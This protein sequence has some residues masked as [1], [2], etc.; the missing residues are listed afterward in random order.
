MVGDDRFASFK[1]I[2][3]SAVFLPSIGNIVF[4]SVLFVLIF[5]V[6]NG[7]LGDGDTGYH[8]KTG[9]LILQ[10][11]RI[12]YDDP[13][14]Y[15]YPPMKWTAHEW[16]AEIVMATIFKASGLTGVVVFFAVILA[17]T[18]WLL[19]RVLRTQSDDVVLCIVITLLATVTSSTHWLARPHVFSL[20][21]TVVWCHVLQQFQHGS[22][23][24]LYLLPLLM[25]FWVNLHGGYIFGLI[26]ITIYLAGNVLNAL[27]EPPYAA[28]KSTQKVK[29]L[30]LLLLACLG[31]CMINPY[32]PKILWFPIQVTSDRFVMDRVIEFLS[33]NFHDALPFKY[34]LLVVI[35]A[36]ALS[37]SALNPIEFAL[38]LLLTYM[39]LYS[40]RHVSLFAIVLA[41]LLL[42][43][44]RGIIDRMPDAILTSYQKRNSN[45]K[46]IDATVNGYV[47]PLLSVSLIAAYLLT[48]RLIIKFNEI[49]FPVAAVEFLKREPI[50]G[51]MFNND[52][53]GDYIIFSAWPAYRVFMDGRNDMYGEKYGRDYLRIANVQPEWKETLRKYDITW[54]IF[55]TPS[56]L[57]AALKDQ[58]DW[59]EIYS[60]R[61][62][63][64]FVK[65]DPQHASLI[66]KYA[67]V[68][69][70]IAH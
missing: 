32:G 14:S 69:E 27:G 17:T 57:T 51:N 31:V 50:S 42:K 34:M 45:L 24:S 23:R 49:T 53:F 68:T 8:I 70:G 9:E 1:A 62:A 28:Q 2:S 61:V 67:V 64:I 25:L 16:L 56:A 37:R 35:G 21:L 60:D 38:V 54:V 20:L 29:A 3:M 19:Y 63:T 52:E 43:T 22:L 58:K 66:N 59:Q 33:P 10:N 4:L 6:G 65:R 55:D 26:L 44:A 39:S 18:H 5:S 36:L 11:W 41:P 13:Y 46:A 12:P 40:V 15:H 47:W 7:L 48:G 30:L